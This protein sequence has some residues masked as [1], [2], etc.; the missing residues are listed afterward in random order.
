MKRYKLILFFILF[1]GNLFAQGNYLMEKTFT[2]YSEYLSKE[3]GIACKIPEKFANLNKYNMG[4]KVRKDKDK[5]TGNMYGLTL[6]SDNKECMVIY[7]AFP[8]KVL[9]E[10][11]V[12]RERRSLPIYPRSQITSEI[13]T[14]L[15]LYYSYGHP[16]NNDSVKFDFN[17]YV[18]LV[19]GKRAHEMFNADSIYIY[20]IPGADSVYFIDQSLEK[21]R[22]KKYPHCMSVFISKN[23]RASMDFKFFF[24]EKGK[25]KENE[26][27]AML[28]EQI[29]YED[30]FESEKEK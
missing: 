23:G 27:I 15:G 3:F 21:M 5:H 16:Q 9:A 6:I 18:T 13:K 17:D 22:Q 11:I 29:W 10:N 28:S 2:A 19:A 1:S 7:S 25:K 8:N 20:D 14:A 30:D 26:Y 12:L 4:W 24:T